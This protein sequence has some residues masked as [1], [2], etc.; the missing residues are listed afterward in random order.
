M[1]KQLDTLNT[2]LVDTFNEI[3]KVEEQSLR[4]ATRETVL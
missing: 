1:D 3:L 4:R 2:L